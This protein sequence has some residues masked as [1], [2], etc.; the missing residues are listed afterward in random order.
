MKKHRL[1]KYTLMLILTVFLAVML[2]I[3]FYTRNLNL[4]EG[5]VVEFEYFLTELNDTCLFQS[6]T[7][8]EFKWVGCESAA[9]GQYYTIIGRAS[10][11]TDNRNS[12]YIFVD[13][14]EISIIS[15]DLFS[16]KGTFR[17]IYGYFILPI[18]NTAIQMRS[19]LAKYLSGDS[20]SL[21]LGLVLGS[22][23]ADF[24]QE[25]RLLIQNLGLSHMVAVSGFHLSVIYLLVVS[26]FEKWFSPKVSLSLIIVILVWY[27]ILVSS[28]ASLLRALLMLVFSL[29]GRI[30]FKKRPISLFIFVQVFALLV[31][32]S[33]SFLY[34]V[35]FLLSFS[36][37]LGVLLIGR[38]NLLDLRQFDVL[39]QENSWLQTLFRFGDFIKG[40]IL[41]S[42]GAQ[43]L[44]LPII[45]NVFGE[46]SPLGFLSCLLFSGWISLIVSWCA[47]LLF[48]AWFLGYL[49]PYFVSFLV[50]YFLFLSDVSNLLISSLHFFSR[51]IGIIIFDQKVSIIFVF[52]F[53]SLIILFACYRWHRS[54]VVVNYVF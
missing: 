16:L 27:T 21:V 10:P 51:F 46:F 20:L 37:T 41:A 29:I 5:S 28:P 31:L 19:I 45:I 4:T 25:L 36:S 40:S 24:S 48:L 42:L 32:I 23:F 8:Y 50:P 9:T 52:A 54:Q 18:K 35:G 47:P 33:A 53:Y 14:S 38:L 3:Y 49:L 44:S 2:R 11:W 1:Y 43:L 30:F 34:N 12:G 39:N 15:V 26:F 6:G 17:L 7:G 13:V 22:R